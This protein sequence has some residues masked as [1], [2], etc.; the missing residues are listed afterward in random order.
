MSTPI[1]QFGLPNIVIPAE[2]L[3]NGN[4]SKSEKILFGFVNTLAHNNNG[5]CCKT[6]KYLSKLVGVSPTNISTMLSKLQKEKCIIM[7]RIAAND[8]EYIRKIYTLI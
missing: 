3:F 2:V 7:E 8:G 1:N 6:N 5:H 4:L